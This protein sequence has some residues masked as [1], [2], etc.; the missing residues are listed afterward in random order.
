MDPLQSFAELSRVIAMQR[1]EP[2]TSA[3][4]LVAQFHETFSRS[5]TVRVGLHRTRSGPCQLPK[6]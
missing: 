1:E 3:G 2:L 4:F 6:T 5:A